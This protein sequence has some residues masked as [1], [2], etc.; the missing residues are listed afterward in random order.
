MKTACATGKDRG[1]ECALWWSL[2]VL[3]SYIPTNVSLCVAALYGMAAASRRAIGYRTDCFA[4][5]PFFRPF[6]VSF[7]QSPLPI[8]LS[9]QLLFSC[10]WTHTTHTQS[11]G[12]CSDIS[13][14]FTVAFFGQIVGLPSLPAPTHSIY[15][16]R[17]LCKSMCSP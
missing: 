16:V 1:V 15:N 7:F 17:V 13:P 9:P 6:V 11:K 4:C 12:L 8:L 3:T 14:P 10:T 2:L 5:R